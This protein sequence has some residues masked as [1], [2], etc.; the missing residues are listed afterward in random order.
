MK[1]YFVALGIV[2]SCIALS[3]VAFPSI[4]LGLEAHSHSETL[5]GR[6]PETLPG[7]LPETLPGTL[8]GRLP[9][10]L[11]A[12]SDLPKVL[13][14]PKPPATVF[15]DHEGVSWERAHVLKTRHYVIRSNVKKP[16]LKL[17]ARVLEKLARRYYRVF[18]YR[19]NDFRFKRNEVWIYK[20]REEFF[21]RAK[22]HRGVG[23][24]YSPLTKKIVAYHGRFGREDDPHANT[25]GVLAHEA[26]HQFQNLIIRQ[27]NHAP[28]W[29]IEGLAVFFEATE[30]EGKVVRIGII[31]RSRLSTVKR[32]V[33]GG[34]YIRLRDL[35]RTPHHRFSGFHYAHAWALIHWMVY[36]P[37]KKGKKLLNWFW[38]LCATRP[39]KPEDFEKGVKAM[40]YD[41]DELE[42]KWKDWVRK[43]DP[44]KDPARRRS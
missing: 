23:G 19:G 33:Q 17:Y 27:M 24:F 6:L 42:R 20:D 2:F 25:V 9:G 28:I 32:A 5:P 1:R 21:A 26:T 15:D 11:G 16:Y 31:P 7:R 8:P 3:S 39:T 12:E 34:Q 14:R 13:E 38:K 30:A 43:L 40:G 41:M 29:L 44:A 22:V 37:E 36:G 4:S 35:I 18:Q 10:T